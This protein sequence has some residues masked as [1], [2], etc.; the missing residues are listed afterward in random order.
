MSS[1]C[2][3]SV[4][5]PA[6]DGAIHGS[7]AACLPV[8]RAIVGWKHHATIITALLVGCLS[9]HADDTLRFNRDIRPILSTYCYECHGPA[10]SR[11]KGGL[12]LSDGNSATKANE[13]GDAAIV[14][15]AAAKSLVMQLLRSADDDE[16]MPPPETGK[17]PSAGQIA[18]LEKWINAGAMYQTHWSFTPPVRPP[19]PNTRRPMNAID[20]FIRGRLK[21]SELKPS[22]RADRPTLIRRVSLALTGLPPTPEDVAAFIADDS[23]GA[24]EKLVDRLLASP[25]HGERMAHNWLDAGRYADTTGYAADKARSNWLYRDWVVNAF[26]DNMKFD[27]FT[28]EQLAGDM[29][30]KATVAQ[31]IATGFHRNSMQALGNNPRKEE[32]RVKGIVDRIDTTGRVWL[33]MTLACAECHDHKFDPISQKEYY[34]LFAIFNNVPHHGNAFGIHGP[35]IDVDPSTVFA[36]AAAPPVAPATGDP[37]ERLRKLAAAIRNS[38]KPAYGQWSFDAPAKGQTLV[39]DSPDDNGRSLRLG[40]EKPATVSIKDGFDVTGDLAISV[41]IKTRSNVADIVSKYDWRA[42]QRAYVFGLGGEGDNS[43]IPGHLYAWVSETAET[44]DGAITTSSIA[45]NDGQWHHVAMHYRAGK[46]VRLF[47]DGVHDTNATITG[48]VPKSIAVSERNL[49]IGGGY[50]TSAAVNDYFL[51]GNID[52]LRIDNTL[53]WENA[54]G[55]AAIRK[56]LPA[57]AKTKAKAKLVTA[58]VMQEIPTPRKTFIHVRGNF[59]NPGKQVFPGVPAALGALQAAKADRL[60]FARWLVK[61]DHPLVARVTVNRLWQQL[62]GVGLVR[63]VEDFGA[64]GE[65]PS[66]PELLDWLAVEFVDCGWD[67][68]HMLKLMVMSQTFQQQSRVTPEVLA[69]DYYNRLLSH[70]PRLRLPAEQIRD[71]ALAI[72]GRL[73]LKMGGP[74]VH[75]VQPGHIGEFR[76]GTAGKWTASKGDARYRRG[77]YTYWQRMYLYPSMEIFDAPSREQSCVGRSRSNTALQSLVSLNDP[78]FA[79]FAKLFAVRILSQNLASDRDRLDF[80][81]RCALARPPSADEAT[82]LLAFLASQKQS[83]AKDNAAAKALSAGMPTKDDA[84]GYA[85]WVMA[86]STILNLDETIHRP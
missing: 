75:P 48:R 60:S 61:G 56:T 38:G 18:I 5:L 23:P 2:K 73:N 32:F 7:R 54:P 59:E 42:G 9:A 11:P 84:A 28:V 63:T 19:L 40:P 55:L 8:R 26:N 52:D 6:H 24:Y 21:Q 22:P 30:P 67:M 12:R 66:H 37:S 45:V 34:Q 17:R 72:S 82:M 29:L 76:D 81:Y 49:V 85:A 62:F 53:R 35:R 14:P 50:N 74:G 70:A 83:F 39:G 79:E 58:Q 3:S 43:G 4:V 33:G 47:I 86:A 15:G 1:S 41:W 64:Q 65:W 10:E 68:R 36:P 27:Q 20:A 78:V 31:K 69:V 46:D 80:A 44:W 57:P 51:D 77:L 71:N 25:H 16:R 13:D